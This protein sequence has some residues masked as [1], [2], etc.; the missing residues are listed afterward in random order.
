MDILLVFFFD[1]R[2]QIYVFYLRSC[3]ESLACCCFI[4]SISFALVVFVPFILKLVFYTFVFFFVLF[5][6]K[7]GRLYDVCVPHMHVAG[8]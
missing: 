8:V 6:P 2:F 7:A 4:P 3:S 5:S 1:T